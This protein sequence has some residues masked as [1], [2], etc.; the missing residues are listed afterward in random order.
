MKIVITLPFLILCYC[1]CVNKSARV[2][3]ETKVQRIFADTSKYKQAICDLD[4]INFYQ[5]LSSQL[6][7]SDISTIGTDS[8]EYRVWKAAAFCPFTELFILKGIDTSWTISY[9]KMYPR[10]YDYDNPKHKSWNPLK[11]PIIDSLTSK[12]LRLNL[13]M[14]IDINSSI[15]PDSIWSL[16]SQ[17]E[18]K[19]NYGAT[20]GSWFSMEVASKNKYKFLFYNNPTGYFS[21]EVNHTKF[22]LASGYVMDI[23]YKLIPSP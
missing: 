16:P 4:L 20:D 11:D 1:A 19:G 8:I 14:I 12:S 9:Y 21:Q 18:I 7:L 17:C 23:V 10:E 6:N 2:K 15:N 3:T 13:N 5:K 22:L